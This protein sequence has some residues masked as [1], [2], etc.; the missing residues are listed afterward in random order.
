MPRLLD[1]W[2]TGF[3]ELTSTGSSP[4]AFRRWGAISAVAG[5]LERKV[6]VVSQGS[7]VYPNIYTML[8]GPPGVGKSVVT[9][10][11]QQLWT[12]LSNHYTAPSDMSKASLIDELDNAVRSVAIR[13]EG[14]VQFNSLKILTNELATLMNTYD[15]A[16]MAV[17]TDLYDCAPYA[18]RKR[19]KKDP[20][21]IPRPQLNML[22]ATTPSQLFE[23]LPEGAWQQG[24]TSR[25]FMVYSDQHRI[26]SLFSLPEGN[27]DLKKKV[28]KDI[29]DIAAMTGPFTFQPEAAKAIEEWHMSG[30]KPTPDHPRLAHYKTR[31][32]LHMLK[33]CIAVS[34]SQSSDRIISLQHFERT[35]SMLIEAEEKMPDLFRTAGTSSEAQV[36]RELLYFAQT[37]YVKTRKPVPESALVHF[38]QQRVAPY[39]VMQIIDLMEKN[40]A[41]KPQMVNK[42]GKCYKPVLPQT[43]TS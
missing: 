31:R 3:E 9:S 24:F 13:E 6:W 36:A 23:Y 5:V 7:R 17:L 11:V 35:L 27:E 4:L 16:M 8:L 33:L 26:T 34:A 37:E 38:L 20:I 43:P 10:T 19:S 25:A 21:N 30:G 29:R 2:I 41:F 1:D 28:F 39:M 18:E 32:T 12:G 15:A 14:T 40:G 22:V 42:V